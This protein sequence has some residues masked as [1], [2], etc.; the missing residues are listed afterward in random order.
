MA[1]Q[2]ENSQDLFELAKILKHQTDFQQSMVGR[3]LPVLLEKP[4]R[5][6]GQLVGKSPYLHAVHLQ[7]TADQVGQI[8][9]VRIVASERNSLSGEVG[10][11]DIP[12]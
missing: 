9:D 7:A 1:L 3:E 12:R 11:A 2:I 8:V 10:Q 4:G 5:K 6:Q